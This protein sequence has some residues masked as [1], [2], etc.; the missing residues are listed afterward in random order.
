MLQ[1]DGTRAQ[2]F[3]DLLQRYSG[4]A[5]RLDGN[6]LRE[7]PSPVPP[8]PYGTSQTLVNIIRKLIG[9]DRTVRM[10]VFRD[11]PATGLI[12]T[13]FGHDDPAVPSP[14]HRPRSVFMSQLE[15]IERHRP[16]V[17]AALAGHI[18]GEYTSAAGLQIT[19]NS[20][21]LPHH[22]IG[23]VVEAHVIRDLTGRPISSAPS[24]TMVPV[25]SGGV[26]LRRHYGAGND[27]AIRFGPQPGNSVLAVTRTS[28]AQ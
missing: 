24:E 8:N 27:Y 5:L 18:L 4:L 19:T 14:H 26:I 13:F 9:S 25:S 22:R 1:M 15:A 23:L 28:M 11:A 12:D 2:A 16:E 21:F 6:V 7:V 17:A 10:D 20:G 3:V